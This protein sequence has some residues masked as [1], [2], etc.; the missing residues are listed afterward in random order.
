VIYAKS[1]GHKKLGEM[2]ENCATHGEFTFGFHPEDHWANP[3]NPTPLRDV[4]VSLVGF[5]KKRRK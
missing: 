1:Y 3:D 5:K 4:T 2:I